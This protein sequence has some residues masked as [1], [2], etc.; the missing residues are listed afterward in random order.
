MNYTEL[1]NSAWELR[2]QGLIS[3]HE[4]DLY[5]YLVYKSYVLGWKNPFN[6]PTK[7]ICAVL[8][9][10]RNALADRRKKLQELGLI[11]FTEGIT[12]QRPAAYR[13][14][15]PLRGQKEHTNTAVKTE[16]KKRAHSFQKP[17]VEEISKYCLERENDVNAQTF[18]DFYESKDWMVGRNKM[19][20]WQASVRTWENKQKGDKHNFANYD[21]S[22][23][24][25][26][27][28]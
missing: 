2:E 10:N 11:K 17:T 9:M 21:N 14:C 5:C 28:F 7:V 26:V 1:T 13:I 19:K 16:T 15:M 12:R 24:S 6:Q 23:K 22:K 18:F 8:G 20:D 27:R 25:Y 3:I 4:H